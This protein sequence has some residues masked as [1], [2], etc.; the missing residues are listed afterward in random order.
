LAWDIF[1]VDLLSVDLYDV[2]L[3]QMFPKDTKFDGA[4]FKLSL[5]KELLQGEIGETRLFF[6]I[7]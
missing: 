1:Y 4:T 6:G 7:M 2:S 3:L 5:V